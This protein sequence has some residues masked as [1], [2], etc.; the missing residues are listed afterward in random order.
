MLSLD[1]T[2]SNVQSDCGIR[3]TCLVIQRGNATR[4]DLRSTRFWSLIKVIGDRDYFSGHRQVK[5]V[6]VS[7]GR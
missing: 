3:L 6:L 5:A 2:L 1:L 7:H 4:R